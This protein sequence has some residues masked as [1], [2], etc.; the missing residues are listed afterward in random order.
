MYMNQNNPKKTRL[1]FQHLDIYLIEP[2]WN[3]EI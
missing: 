2:I 1:I 3:K